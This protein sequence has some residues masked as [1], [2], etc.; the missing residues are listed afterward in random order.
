MERLFSA[1]RLVKAVDAKT[2]VPFVAT[3]TV[4]RAIG[5]KEPVP[6]EVEVATLEPPVLKKLR[7]KAIFSLR[8]D[9]FNEDRGR[10][11]QIILNE[12]KK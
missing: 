12:D 9:L 4:M 11:A 6:V 10:I 8:Q 1:R 2:D 3:E 7:S 5:G